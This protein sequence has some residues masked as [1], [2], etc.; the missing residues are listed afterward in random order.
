MSVDHC[1]QSHFFHGHALRENERR[2]L[3]VVALTAVM[4]VA[5]I[6]SGWWFGSMAL[7]ADGFHMA[8]H[9]GALGISAFAY[10]YARKHAH[11]PR[12]SFG[13]GKVS[14]LAGFTSA[15]ILAL[16]GLGVVIESFSRLITPQPISY[17]D[18]IVVAVIGLLVNVA[19]AKIL[20]A[21]HDHHSHDHGHKHHHHNHD[22]NLRSAYLH[23]VADALTSVMA[24]VALFCGWFLGWSWMDPV[25]GIVGALVIL[26]WSYGLLKDTVEV[27]LDRTP[28]DDVAQKVRT[29]LAG[30]NIGISDLHIWRVAPHAHAA[31]LAINTTHSLTADQVREWLKPLGFAHVTVE[32]NFKG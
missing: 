3:I 22:N 12:Y 19:S 25:I 29:V 24:L 9:A 5:E 15:I 26:I 21:K 31:I 11:D 17:E 30:R 23:V 32:V 4:M 8:T 7:L 13:T 16:T 10:A 18:A 2:T 28:Q 20:Q 14:D 27:L 6:A 1:S